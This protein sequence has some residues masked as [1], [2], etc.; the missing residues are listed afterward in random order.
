MTKRTDTTVRNASFA[1]SAGIFRC[2]KDWPDELVPRSMSNI[3]QNI[4]RFLVAE[5]GGEI[6]GTI[7]W[8]ILPEL[9][10]EASPSIEI[11]SVSVRRDLQRE[12]I[13][14]RL[15]ERAIRRVAKYRPGQVIV[16]TFAPAF[17]GRLGF[18]RV[19]KETLM[20]KLYKGCMNCAKY[21][22]PFTCP[23]IAMALP[24]GGAR[25]GA[26]RRERGEA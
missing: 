15:V 1:D 18:V 16:L 3:L 17:F 19:S 10:P 24:L 25:A 4:D 20:Y 14:R 7:A 23:E 12:G 6:V 22:S 13:G 8:S 21:S 5:R 2:I 11:Q 9:D 26:V